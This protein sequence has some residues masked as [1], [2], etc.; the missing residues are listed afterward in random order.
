MEST[1]G[2]PKEKSKLITAANLHQFKIIELRM[3]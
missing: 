2:M 1:F 3:E